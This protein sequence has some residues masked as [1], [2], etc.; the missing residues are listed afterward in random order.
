MMIT[1]GNRDRDR[2]AGVTVVTVFKF[3]HPGGN[4]QVI[5]ALVIRLVS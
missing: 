4:L 2:P 3:G 1:S 5:F